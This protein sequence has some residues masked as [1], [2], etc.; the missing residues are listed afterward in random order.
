MAH[1]GVLMNIDMD[2]TATPYSE[3][4]ARQ[5]FQEMILGIEYRKPVLSLILLHISKPN[6][7]NS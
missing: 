3:D 4:V 6:E 1:R 2:E 5:F 7:W